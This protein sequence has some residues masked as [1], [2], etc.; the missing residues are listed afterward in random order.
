MGITMLYS[1]LVKV[2][3]DIMKIGP[4]WL[5]CYRC[6]PKLRNTCVHLKLQNALN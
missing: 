2:A 1:T 4:L 3:V 5:L 6:D